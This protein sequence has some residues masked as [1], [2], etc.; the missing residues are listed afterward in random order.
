M[1]TVLVAIAIGA[2]VL[3]AIGVAA[4]SGGIDGRILYAVLFGAWALLIFTAGGLR[5]M[6]ENLRHLAVWFGVLVLLAGLYAYRSEL[7]AIGHRVLGAIVPG[8]ALSAGDEVVVYRTSGGRFLV[9]GKVDGTPVRFL[10]DTGATGVA[11][12]AADARRAGIAT[13][14][15]DYTLPSHTA[16]GIALVAPVRLQTVEVGGI[17][18]K[19]VMASV[20]KEGALGSNLLGHS[21]LE[22]LASYEVRGD[23]LIL[24]GH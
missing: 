23:R 6:G 17:V 22:R 1:R 16:N 8:M 15:A 21:F 4:V 9:D 10:F 12:T 24:R 19:D 7:Q 13:A 3:G 5:Q 2:A 20:S 14:A 18:V 11:L